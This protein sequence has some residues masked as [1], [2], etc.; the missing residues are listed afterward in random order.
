MAN[1]PEYFGSWTNR[2]HLITHVLFFISYLVTPAVTIGRLLRS[3]FS[4]FFPICSSGQTAGSSPLRTSYHRVQASI[5]MRSLQLFIYRLTKT[6][7]GSVG[8]FCSSAFIVLLRCRISLIEQ[9]PKI[10]TSIRMFAP[11][12]STAVG[13]LMISEVTLIRTTQ[14]DLSVL[15]E[16]AGHLQNEVFVALRCFAKRPQCVTYVVIS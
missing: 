2:K 10:S 7:S 16:I 3:S 12:A 14:A 13:E 5:C 8:F 4:D 11:V 6:S 1:A 15:P 9:L